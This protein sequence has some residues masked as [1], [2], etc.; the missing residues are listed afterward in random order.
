MIKM[1]TKFLILIIS[2][3]T[4]GFTASA[5]C[6][7]SIE[8][9]DSYGDGWDGA[10]VDVQVNGVVVVDDFTITT[11]SFGSATFSALNGDDIDVIYTSGAYENEHTYEVFD[12]DG[13]SLGSSGP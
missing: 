2:I 7:H 4:I 1:C 3:A 9:Y 13:K 6:D 11:G 10:M 5:Q 8:I 12:G